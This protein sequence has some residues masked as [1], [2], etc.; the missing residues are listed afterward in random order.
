MGVVEYLTA[1][2]DDLPPLVAD[3]IMLDARDLAPNPDIGA[4]AD[5]LR[6]APVPRD[7]G[8]ARTRNRL[9]DFAVRDDI[10]GVAAAP[11]ERLHL[12]SDDRG[13]FPVG[14]L[15]E[16]ER[17][18]LDRELARTGT[19][20]WHRNSGRDDVDALT[21]AYRDGTSWRSV[22]PDFV[23]FSRSGDTV[24]A[25]IVDPHG[26]FLGDALLKLRGLAD[27]AARHGSAYERIEAVANVKG[28][29]WRVLDMQREDVRVAVHSHMES[30]EALYRSSVAVEYR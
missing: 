26:D 10:G 2:R 5:I 23:F 1:Q 7:V 4:D 21:I 17:D 13:V 27:Y 12:M 19:A 6:H 30:A 18:V 16:W 25:S 22:H 15:N 29:G 9:E 20:G 3:R 24:R 8:L 28:I 14:A 11:T